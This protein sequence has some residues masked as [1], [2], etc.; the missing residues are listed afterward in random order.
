MVGREVLPFALLYCPKYLADGTHFQSQKEK[1][2]GLLYLLHPIY[3][4][5]LKDRGIYFLSR[6]KIAI[7]E[8]IIL[9]ARL[10]S[11]FV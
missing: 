1:K 9:E 7:F 4:L 10:L 2:R 8:S 5:P 11:L 6:H 3:L